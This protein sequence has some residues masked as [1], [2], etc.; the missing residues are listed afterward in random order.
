[1][2]ASRILVTGAEL[3]N[4]GHRGFEPVV[5][6]LVQNAR[7][8]IQ[9]AAYVLTSSTTELL[10]LLGVA[11][12]R[13]VSVSIVVNRLSRQHPTVRRWLEGAPSRWRGFIVGDFAHNDRR[14]L[15][16]KVCVTDRSRAVVGSANFTWGGLV[17]NYEIGVEVE[18]VLAWKLG[19]LVDELLLMSSVVAE[20]SDTRVE[21]A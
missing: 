9:L 7:S 6:D 20:A 19:A 18:G 14:E 8:E 3:L 15:H 10:N 4:K 2:T 11:A 5:Q 12:S 21:G 16:A 17:S 13:G 1:M